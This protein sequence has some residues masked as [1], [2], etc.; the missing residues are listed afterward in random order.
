[1]KVLITGSTGQVGKKLY[2]SLKEN[3]NGI[4]I[5]LNQRKASKNLN[6]EMNHRIIYNSIDRSFSFDEHVDILVHLASETVEEKLMWGTNYFGTKRIMK[7]AINSGVKKI[8]YLSSIAVY[9]NINVGKIDENYQCRP[10][11]IY[12]KSKYAAEKLIISLCVKYKIQYN[13]IRPS[14]IIH[15]SLNNKYPLLNYFKSIKKNQLFYFERP[16]D[17]FLNYVNLEDVIRCLEIFINKSVNNCTFI[18]NDPMKIQDLTSIVAKELN[19]TKPIKVIPYN[20]GYN[21]ACFGDCIWF[22]TGKKPLFN[23][24]VFLELTNKNEFDGSFISNQLRFEYKGNFPKTIKRLL[25][26]YIKKKLL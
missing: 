15:Y 8:I 3:N 20:I 18:L 13:V 23:S 26:K 7:W 25:K 16:E 24:A 1:M 14:N 9:G 22:L 19:V 10:T 12:G 17:V 2:E 6:D 21:L 11:S 5:I 4:E